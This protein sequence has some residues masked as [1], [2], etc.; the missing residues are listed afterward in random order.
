MECS[1]SR[2][3]PRHSQRF[4][5]IWYH[6]LQCCQHRICTRAT[7]DGR[8]TLSDLRL[9]IITNGARQESFLTD[10][11]EYHDAL[12]TYFGIRL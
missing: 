3:S 12:L 9:I 4:H 6:S 8:I 10:E 5:P 7:P 1:L 11:A 2:P